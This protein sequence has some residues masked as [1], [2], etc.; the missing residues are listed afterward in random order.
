MGSDIATL[1]LIASEEG[2]SRLAASYRIFIS[3]LTIDPILNSRNTS[4][5][6]WEMQVLDLHHSVA[7]STANEPIMNSIP[8]QQVISVCVRRV[9]RSRLAHECESEENRLASCD[10]WHSS[11]IRAC[12]ERALT[13]PGHYYLTR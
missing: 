13:E 11:S 7:N 3:I 1:S 8:T 6:V 5:Q 9:H 10:R 2:I 4:S 12:A